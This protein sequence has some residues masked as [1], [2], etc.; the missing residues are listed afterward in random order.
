MKELKHLKGN[1][2]YL[3]PTGA[4]RRGKGSCEPVEE[5][6][7]TVGTKYIGIGR[8]KYSV[9]NMGLYYLL[10]SG[11]HYDYKLFLS[12]PERSDYIERMSLLSEIKS[13]VNHIMPDDCLGLDS[14]RAIKLILDDRA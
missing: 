8:S 6:I 11:H 12:E 10:T 4:N 9:R 2:A 14:L 7:E 3:I 5:I 1:L 13:V